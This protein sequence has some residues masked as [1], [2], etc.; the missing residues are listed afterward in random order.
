MSTPTPASYVDGN[1]IAEGVF[2][3]VRGRVA[4]LARAPRL[5]IITC[6]P[7]FETQKYLALKERRAREVGIHTDIVMVPGDARTEDV[8]AAIQSA[9]P[10]T[11]GIV[12]QL[13]LPAHIESELVLASIPPSHD[14]DA[15]NPQ[16]TD[17]MPPVVGAIAEILARHGVVVPGAQVTIIGSGKL[18]GR[19]AYAW[20]VA[21]GAHVS[22]V[23][24]D[25]ADI[26]HHTR[27]ADIVVCGAGVPRLLTPPMVREGVVI[28]DAGTSEDGGVLVGDADPACAL[29]ASLFTPV[30][31]GVGPVTVAILLKNVVDCALRK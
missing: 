20:F 16:T 14:V 24:K 22:L 21:E 7:N 6:D 13:P 18:V 9:V 30:P 8:V 23:T 27:Q 1:T 31:G 26:A 29:T 28:I 17:I 15:L 4:E 3:R 25:T 2:E 11:D 19:P 5:T 12:V 10:G